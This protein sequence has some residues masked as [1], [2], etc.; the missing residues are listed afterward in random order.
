MYTHTQKTPYKLEP[1]GGPSPHRPRPV[2]HRHH[3]VGINGGFIGE[4]EDEEEGVALGL[5]TGIGGG[6]QRGSNIAVRATANTRPTATEDARMII[7]SKGGMG[8]AGTSGRDKDLITGLRGGEFGGSTGIGPELREYGSFSPSTLPCD[9]RRPALSMR[10]KALLE[11][12][13]RKSLLAYPCLSTYL[14]TVWQIS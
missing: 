7:N 11:Q 4:G 10:S 3:A 12:F 14:H 5:G 2:S 6:R 13:F 9:D 1:S 8:I